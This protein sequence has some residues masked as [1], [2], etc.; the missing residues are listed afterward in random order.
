MGRPEAVGPRGGHGGAS[1]VA[2]WLSAHVPF[3]FSG[4]RFTGLDPGC[5]HGTAW[6][7]MLWQASHI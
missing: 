2:Q 4:P 1:P 7:D 5:G 6:Q 3:C